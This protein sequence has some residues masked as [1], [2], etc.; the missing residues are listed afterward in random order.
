MH[1]ITED[2]PFYGLDAQALAAVG[3]VIICSLSGT[4]DTLKAAIYTRHIYGA[5]D[6][7]FGRRF[8]DVIEFKENRALAIDYGRFHDTVTD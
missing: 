6:V 3:I 5:E 8:V 2:S 1:K 7:L 4:D